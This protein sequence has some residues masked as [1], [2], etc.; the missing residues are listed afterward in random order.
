MIS[1]ETYSQ[2]TTDACVK[3][4]VLEICFERKTKESV[5][6]T[7]RTITVKI[8][9]ILNSLCAKGCYLI[10]KF[11]SAIRRVYVFAPMFWL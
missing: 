9:A 3:I 8:L 5:A 10:L 7:F 2:V 1:D 4:A 6:G 11:E